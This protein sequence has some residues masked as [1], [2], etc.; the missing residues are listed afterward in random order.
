ML[1]WSGSRHHDIDLTMWVTQRNFQ[2]VAG[3]TAHRSGREHE[4]LVA[5]VGLLDGDIVTNHLV[6]WMS[7]LKSA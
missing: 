4:D 3:Q 5:F 6:N 7:P 1:E 2:S